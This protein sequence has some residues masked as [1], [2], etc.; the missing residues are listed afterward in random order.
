MI[1]DVFQY[2]SIRTIGLA[3][4]V[5]YA[6]SKGIKMIRTEQK[7]KA[8]GGRSPYVKYYAPFGNT[9]TFSVK[10]QILIASLNQELI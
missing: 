9:G 1:E 3:L 5:L 8:L 2:L 7:I 6:I 4:V 10:K